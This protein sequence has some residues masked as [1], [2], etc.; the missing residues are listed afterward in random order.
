MLVRYGGE[1]FLV[2]L[3]EVPGPGAVV[4]AGRIRR[5]VA[6][7]RRSRSGTNRSR[8]TVSLGVAARLD[9]GPESIDT[10]SRAPTKRWRSPSSAAATA[11]SPSR[12]DAPSPPSRG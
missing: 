11:L 6:K 4:V 2:M 9:E 7:P 5:S 1:E 8:V 12:W 3:P 10:C